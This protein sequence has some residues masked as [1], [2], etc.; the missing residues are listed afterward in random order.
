MPNPQQLADIIELELLRSVEWMEAVQCAAGAVIWFD[1]EEMGLH[2]WA[3][4]VR[5]EPCPPIKAGPGRVVLATVTHDNS[6][7]MDLRLA[8]I[9]E[10]LHL[11]DRHRLFS[12]TRHVSDHFLTIDLSLCLCSHDPACGFG[13]MFVQSEK[14]VESHGGKPRFSSDNPVN[15]SLN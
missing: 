4:V 12:A 14:Y 11:T 1:L 5:V 6:F 3:E 10:P 7:L 8:G 15:F 2:G 9:A 13:G